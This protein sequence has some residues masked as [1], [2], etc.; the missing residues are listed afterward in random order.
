MT[1]ILTPG[2]EEDIRDQL[3]WGI[4]HFGLETTLQTLERI[5]QFIEIYLPLFPDG[6]GTYLRDIDAFEAP[7]PRTPFILFYRHEPNDTLRV[8][9]LFHHAQERRV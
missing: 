8:L 7:I 5:T 6:T 3:A 1:V 4:E 9:A 2:V